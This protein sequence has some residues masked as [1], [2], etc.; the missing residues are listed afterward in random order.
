MLAFSLGGRRL[1]RVQL[2]DG[3]VPA[4]V[5]FVGRVGQQISFFLPG[6]IQLH[7]ILGRLP[8]NRRHIVLVPKLV[9]FSCQERRVLLLRFW[10]VVVCLIFRCLLLAC[11]WS[12]RI[13]Q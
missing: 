4:K 12:W 6:C 3:V 10:G 9:L 5:K 2:V 1:G 7:V 13:S 11:G 8:G